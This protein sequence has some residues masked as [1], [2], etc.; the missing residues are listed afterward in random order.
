MKVRILIGRRAGEVL[1]FPV[2]VA[3][4]LLAEGQAVMPEAQAPQPAAPAGAAGPSGPPLEEAA[5]V[6]PPEA[7]IREHRPSCRRL[8][9]RG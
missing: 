8:H 4:R 5:V 1:D 7:A 9:R 6:H 3:R 2:P